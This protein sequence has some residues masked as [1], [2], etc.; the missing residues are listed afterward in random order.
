MFICVPEDA[1]HGDAASLAVCVGDLVKVVVE[2]HGRTGRL[3]EAENNFKQAL[4]AL[5]NILPQYLNSVYIL[6]NYARCLRQLG[7]IDEAVKMEAKAENSNPG[8]IDFSIC[9]GLNL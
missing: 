3:A 6:E 2:E 5:K 4:Q 1:G 7:K 8:K 9:F